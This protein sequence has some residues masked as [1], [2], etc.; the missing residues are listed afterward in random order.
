MEIVEINTPDLLGRTALMFVALKGDLET[1]QWLIRLGADI[2][3]KDNSGGSTL[4]YAAVS[5]KDCREKIR[6]LLNL[7]VDI[8]IREDDGKTI[9]M[10]LA[11]PTLGNIENIPFLLEQGCD[12]NAQDDRGRTALMY[13]A[14][15]NKDSTKIL[16]DSGADM[17]IQD[18]ENKTAF[19]H[20]VEVAN[21]D[22]VN[23]LL[24]KF[25]DENIKG[26]YIDR[27]LIK[28]HQLISVLSTLEDPNEPLLVASFLGYPEIVQHF[29]D[30]GI[31][32]NTQRNTSGYSP[33]ALAIVRENIDVIK[34]LLKY[35]ADIN[36]PDSQ[37]ETPLML[38]Y[39]ASNT[40]IIK[41]LLTR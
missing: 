2:H 5:R 10:K 4:S 16:L 3:T 13:A 38:A 39:R 32:V 25:I 14:R 41:F 36:I 15:S 34:L 20:A 19:Q 22:I 31:D 18:Y 21:K 17:Y 8:N 30:L 12:I 7:G 35:E 29:I 11:G 26:T 33:L 24:D 6:I 23:L 40:E 9:I 1:F 27:D 37:G 28:K